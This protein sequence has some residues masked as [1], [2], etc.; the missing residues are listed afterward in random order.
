VFVGRDP[1]RRLFFTQAAAGLAIRKRDEAKT[2]VGEGAAPC[3][4]T[5]SVT[6]QFRMKNKC[7][8]TFCGDN[9]GTV[10]AGLA[11]KTDGLRSET[12]V[13]V[14]TRAPSNTGRLGLYVA[15]ILY[16]FTA[17]D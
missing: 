2:R 16:T 9:A 17:F 12:P 15:S 1:R 10:G 11:S 5:G 6:N 3:A 7:I 4:H 13:R 14:Q 8:T